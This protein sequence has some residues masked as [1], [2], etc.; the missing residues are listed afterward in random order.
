MSLDIT[1]HNPETD[2]TKEMNWLR[3][4]YGLE[5]WARANYLYIKKEEPSPDLW[6][7]CNQW[8][9]DKSDQVDRPVFLQVVKQYGEVIMN[10]EKGYFWFDEGAQRQ[11]LEPHM[12]LLPASTEKVLMQF[13]VEAT[14]RID[15]WGK[16]HLGVPM[17]Y[18]GSPVFGLSDKYR[19]TAHTL[20]RYKEWYQQLIDLAEMLQI[21]G[22][23]FY[24]SN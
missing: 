2:E 12:D 19:P 10:L 21:P 23:T 16:E 5:R 18:F 4:P 1:V 8:N 11:F 20:E 14:V 3:N 22:T 17:C 24:C 7:V 13:G 15:L 6:D 9:Y